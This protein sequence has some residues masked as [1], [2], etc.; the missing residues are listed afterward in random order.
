MAWPLGRARG[1]HLD[2]GGAR[3]ALRDPRATAAVLETAR[4]GMLRRGL[5]VRRAGAAAVTNIA[6]DHLGDYGVFDLE[7]VADVKLVVARALAAVMA[8]EHT[9]SDVFPSLDGGPPGAAPNAARTA[10]PN[11]SAALPPRP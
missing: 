5:A 7:D 11:S 4:G 8:R 10:A 9:P 3:L 1:D 6:A 2:A